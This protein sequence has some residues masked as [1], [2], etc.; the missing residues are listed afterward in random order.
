MVDSEQLEAFDVGMLVSRAIGL[1]LRGILYD[2]LVH[3]DVVNKNVWQYYLT[4]AD[5]QRNKVS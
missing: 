4:L 5:F 1:N 2:F 3:E